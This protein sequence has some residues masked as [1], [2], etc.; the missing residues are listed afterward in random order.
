MSSASSSIYE[1]SL[2][3]KVESLGYTVK[4]LKDEKRDLMKKLEGMVGDKVK[5]EPSW[6]NIKEYMWDT[7]K[8]HWKEEGR[9]ID[10]IFVN[11]RTLSKFL[12]DKDDSD[13]N[14]SDS[15]DKADTDDKNKEAKDK[16][17]GDKNKG[18]DTGSSKDKSEGKD[19]GSS[20]DKGKNDMGKKDKTLLAE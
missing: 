17:S 15:D 1:K 6:T 20:K 8:D 5:I 7:E 14:D 4:E 19:T 16:D 11:L 12:T 13:S 9:P 2:V 10:H 18:K 3:S